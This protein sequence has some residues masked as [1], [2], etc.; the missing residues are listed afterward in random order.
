MAHDTTLLEITGSNID[1]TPFSARGLSQQLSPLEQMSNQRRTINGTL[2]DLAAS[3]FQKYISSISGNDQQSPAFD[4]NWPGKIVT[5]DCIV[6]LAYP[7]SGGSPA[8]PV[9]PGSSRVEGDFTFYR[10]RLTMIIAS[11]QTTLD[12]WGAIVG[13]Q[14]DLEE[15]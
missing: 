10:P 12:E 7:T 15:V 8:K 11:Y 4:G 6:E 3:Q 13:W 2:I 5:V 9:V 14:L 1:V